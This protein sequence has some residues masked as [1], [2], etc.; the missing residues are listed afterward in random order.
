MSELQKACQ[1]VCEELKKKGA[2]YDAFRASIKSAVDDEIRSSL[3]EMPDSEIL[4]T[5]TIRRIIGEE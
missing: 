2:F 5:K 3:P 4:A 1:T